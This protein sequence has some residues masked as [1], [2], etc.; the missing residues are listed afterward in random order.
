MDVAESAAILGNSQTVADWEK[1]F[2]TR[3]PAAGYLQVFRAA[4]FSRRTPWKRLRLRLLLMLVELEDEESPSADDSY[5][6]KKA[7]QEHGKAHRD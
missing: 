6:R 2:A 3:S 5:G 4:A 7:R 1:A